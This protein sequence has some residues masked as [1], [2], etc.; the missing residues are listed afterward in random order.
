MSIGLSNY[1]G[2]LQGALESEKTSENVRTLTA[3][4]SVSRE[5]EKVSVAGEERRTGSAVD[6]N[7]DLLSH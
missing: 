3:A 2:V 4:K 6:G 7:T 1:L 5:R